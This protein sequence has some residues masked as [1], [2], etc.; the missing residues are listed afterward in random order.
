MSWSAS[1]G[2]DSY[3]VQ[4]KGPGESYSTARMALAIG[5]SYRIR[6]RPGANY[7]V[8]VTPY[9]R[10]VPGRAA[11][12]TG[13]SVG[14]YLFDMRP[15]PLTETALAAG[16][17]RV[18]VAVFGFELPEE[19]GVGVAVHGPSGVGVARKAVADGDVVKVALSMAA[20]ADFDQ[21]GTLRAT[22]S[23][24]GRSLTT[25][26][27]P[28]VAT[29]EQPAA[30]TRL[31]VTAAEW[32]LNVGWSASAGAD[33]Y[34]VQWKGPGE[35][36]SNVERTAT[37]TSTSHSI[38]VRPGASYTVKVTPY[39]G[40]VAG[41]AAE[42]TGSSVGAY[43]FDVIPSPL[44]ED[45]IVA[46]TARFSVSVVGFA[47]PENSGVSVS[48]Q[49]PSGVGVAR[50]AVVDGDIVTVALSMAEG[51]DFD[52]N[53]TLSV[54]VTF[55]GRSLTTQTVPVVATVEPTVPNATSTVP[56]ATSTPAALAGL[57]V[58]AADW[59]LDVS[60]SVSANAD[61]YRVQWKHAGQ[62][63]S[64]RV[65]TAT[66]TTTSYSID[67]QPEIS[68]TVKVTPY[69]GGVPG[70]AAEQ[71]GSSVGAYIYH[72]DPSPLTEEALVAG[73]ASVD[74]AVVGFTLAD[75]SGVSVSVQGPSGV[76]VARHT[77]VDGDIVSVDLS[78]DE[79]ADF[80]V[81]GT[82]SVIVTFSGWSL[83]T[84]TVPVVA[85]VEP[86]VPNATSTVPSA[87]STPAALAGLAVT[88][89]EWRLD[90][91]WS[92]SANADSYRVQWKHDGQAYSPHVRTATTTG[93]SYSIGTQPG[94]GHTVKVTP[95]SGGVP[96]PAA[97]QTGSSVGVYIHQVDPSPLTEEALVAGTA[98]V[99][100]AVVGFTLADGSGVSVS[101]QGPSGV[102]V[103]RQ[104][105]A[106]GNVVNVA[107]SMDE[108]AD[109]DVDGTL[110]VTVTF[111]GR[112]LTTQT[113]PVVAT[114]EP[115]V[116]NATSTVPSAT[117][118]PA[119][120]AGL[121][122]T[123]A[124]WRLDVSWSAS[125]NADS[126]RL[127]WKHDG[128]A[129]SPHVRTAT[130]TGTNY[131]IG[132]QPGVG[133]TVKVTPYAGGVPGPAAE[134]TGS[135]VG[136]YIHQVDPSPLTEEAL[137]AGMASVGVAVVGFALPEDSGVSVSVQGPSGVGVARQTV[138]D[139]NV[140]NVALSMDEGADFDVNGTLSVTVTFSGRSLTTQTVPVVAKVEPTVPNATST[141]PSATSTPAALAGLAVTAAEWRL[142]VGWSAS[143]NADSYRVQWKHGGQAYSPHVRTATTTGTS[144]SIGTQPGLGHTVKVTPYAGDVPGP[145][146][147]QTGSSV[148]AYILQVSPSPLTE[149]ALVAGAASVG[150]ALVGFALPKDSGVSVSV[151][152][153]SGVG[154]ARQ[155]V[156]DGDVVAVALSMDEGAD[157]D[158][159]GTLS[160]TV[161]FSGRSLTTQAVPVVAKVE[162]TV[163]NATSTVPSATST[164]AALVGLAV[165]AAEWRLDVSW[166]ASA[167]ADSYRVQ[168]KHGGQA[169]SSH[170]R[171]ATTT[172]TSY[173]IDMQP[174]F[175]HTVKVTPYAGDVPGP[176]AEQIGSSVG[177]LIQ[178]R[179]PSPLTEESLVAG[180]AFVAVVL[181]GFTFPEEWGDSVS[182]LEPSGVGIARLGPHEGQY[183]S[184][185]LS[186]DE[187][188][189]F[190]IEQTLR[191]SVAV[192]GR[193][194]T[195]QAALVVATVET[196]PDQVTGVAVRAGVLSLDVSW[197]Q[198]PDATSYKVQWRDG[199]QAWGS[200]GAG[201]GQLVVAN[202]STTISGL[203]A[204]TT[205][206]VRVVATKARAKDGLPSDEHA[207]T[208]RS[209]LTDGAALELKAA[210]L[211]AN[212]L[213]EGETKTYTVALTVAPPEDVVVTIASDHAAVVA[214]PVRL[215][216]S[217]ST[218]Q[219]A[220]TVTVESAEDDDALHER[221][222]LTH[223][224]SSVAY[225]SGQITFSVK[226][227]D[228]RALLLDTAPAS[229]GDQ[230]AALVLTSRSPLDRAKTYTVRLASAP[231]TAVVVA[232][233]SSDPAAVVA[234]PTRLTFSTD[235]WG[236]A[237]TVTATA[238]DGA[239]AG[240][241]LRH[242]ASGGDY[243]GHS[244]DLPVRVLVVTTGDRGP[245]APILPTL[246][247]LAVLPGALTPAFDPN[248][249]DYTVSVAGDVARVTVTAAAESSGALVVV[250]TPDASASPGHQVALVSGLDEVVVQVLDAGLLGE[251]RLRI[252]R[253]TSQQPSIAA[254]LGPIAVDVGA[255]KSIDL[256]AGFLDPDGDPLI[257]SASS[258]AP[259]FATVEVSDAQALVTGRAEGDAT[260]SVRA[261]DPTGLS[262][263][264]TLAV[265]VVAGNVVQF[266][267][268]AVSVVEGATAMLTVTMARAKPQRTPLTLSIH[269]DEDPHTHNADHHDYHTDQLALAIPA[270]R[271]SATVG[272]GIHDDE[273]IEPLLESFVV[274]LV[275][276][277]DVTLGAARTATVTIHEGICDRM[278]R[279][280]EA[281]TLAAGD[282]CETV[283]AD[284]LARQTTLDLSR[285]PDC[286]LRLGDLHGFT[287][288]RELSLAGNGLQA[289][290]SGVF[291]GLSRLRVLDLSGN[292][293]N[294]LPPRL[295][296]GLSELAEVDLSDNP[297]APF[298]LTVELARQ[299]A[300][301][302][303]PPPAAIV[304]HV[305][306]GAPFPMHVRLAMRDA[307][308]T[309]EDGA[310]V[311]D[312]PIARGRVA[313]A[314]IAVRPA[315]RRAA[316][317]WPVAA[318][319]VPRSRCSG[320]PCYRGLRTAVGA[321]LALFERTSANFTAPDIRGP[322]ADNDWT[323]ELDDVFR[324][325]AGTGPIGYE[326]T[327][328]DPSV[329]TVA[330]RAGRLV[331]SRSPGGAGAVTITVTASK[332][333]DA[334]STLR[335]TI[336]VAVGLQ[337]FV[338]SWRLALHDIATAPGR[339]DAVRL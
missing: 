336:D 31:T 84:Q 47:L 171:T 317:I 241:T 303:L 58:T 100:V 147:E 25:Q 282:R 139:G 186:M 315:A 280:Q 103:A 67:V 229:A 149:E 35:S 275:P 10:D 101:V 180:E 325:L 98:S 291:A 117:S 333:G 40:R 116:P 111:S 93:T 160:V 183:A 14:A 246:S 200:A 248:I 148:G 26:S 191:M 80:D 127:Q 318:P 223:D 190:D 304:A 44:T 220:Q 89:A 232:V 185:Y 245:S 107:L 298:A 247:A 181:A 198:V 319:A 327:S 238:Q 94:V 2:A 28:V 46:G 226:D 19:S 182:V 21:N 56:S 308:A 126:Y 151:Q 175:G 108:G 322:L 224:P 118:T 306:E 142:D 62:P 255:S 161:T 34:R 262:A 269:H 141:V 233:A 305:A 16:T 312:T 95:Y 54:T 261:T 286:A 128:Q 42:K 231:A 273:H 323:L 130:T 266:K 338:R 143:A 72:V 71:T 292:G 59:R 105:V 152:G 138:A 199:T 109:F 293:L 302:S 55:S 73:T 204:S 237:Q 334:T 124:D 150:V 177:A 189:D 188:V 219:I 23:F 146:A 310:V 1:A 268:T 106:D 110:S 295:F 236:T 50:Q 60:W 267:E 225:N 192:S 213:D 294:T 196:A 45:A 120:L 170:V 328:S 332:G 29:L 114:V 281:M 172:G 165:T 4:W 252:V 75:G 227:N 96:G 287:N 330:T 136:A 206:A 297:G 129:Y 11:Q 39:D 178:Q 337:P 57:T 205:Y 301:P 63:Y 222:A 216:F 218:W 155:T 13:W 24:S 61:S 210:D 244:A 33:T 270:G 299:D 78:M 240:A 83:T 159:N 65:R 87:T 36:Y 69:A 140:V 195:T 313:A 27:V 168:W 203:T 163:P 215:T 260:I 234:A 329:A 254:A 207:G 112:S 209:G 300:V 169:Y 253:T 99:G 12:K 144:Y 276:Q 285:C 38:R 296:E 5:T 307:Q 133:H 242:T 18:S 290:P 176:A 154:V 264:Q 339:A 6:T 85:T 274:A 263:S 70:P 158:V 217:T 164:P 212:G 41:P 321:P 214:G 193:S 79:G 66:A 156:L 91:G 119:A 132:T 250:A 82:L 167:D 272:F 123:A 53:G 309:N 316:W 20:D 102:G 8:K 113:V 201:A 228:S 43:M 277:D 194:L 81:D 32:R 187:D 320:A 121:T 52:T 335:F 314:P 22:V 135:S 271:R 48:V 265:A 104:T 256:S 97:E 77:V 202:A 230:T 15:S 137:A 249:L 208:P 157:F 331:V 326:A 125:A 131:S 134:Q 235:A 166:S 257:Y 259:Q 311:A 243:N 17:A 74:V 278:T 221:V 68:Y 86:T 184:F 145:A 88:A 174:G 3:R 76:G 92:A 289:L 37:A 239:D 251:Y 162:P 279:M 153:P 288:L 173:S 7:T 211:I 64:S 9:K 122:V 258:D 283:T 30:L 115:T 49:G 284:D 324:S 197:N 51:A 179:S 90:V